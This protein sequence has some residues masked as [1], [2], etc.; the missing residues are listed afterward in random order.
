M[1]L[2]FVVVME[3][4]E[5]GR[6]ILVSS[7]SKLCTSPAASAMELMKMTS[8]QPCYVYWARK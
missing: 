6:E 4:T 8:W 2:T 7:L 3:N 1:G 5:W